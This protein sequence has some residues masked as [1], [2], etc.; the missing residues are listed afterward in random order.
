M[1][2]TAVLKIKQWGLGLALFLGCVLG[3][4]AQAFPQKP[5]RVVIGFPPGG[6]IDMVARL[7]AP[8]LS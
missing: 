4:F 5:V 6:G 3:A 2:E 8:K 1:K 7:M